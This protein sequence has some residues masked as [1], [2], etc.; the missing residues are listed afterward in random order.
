MKGR[1]K[2]AAAI[3]T[4]LLLAML[5]CTPAFA[6][7]NTSDQD[8][9]TSVSSDAREKYTQKKGGGRDKVTIMIYMIGSDLESQNGMATAD[10]NEML[11]AAP[12]NGNINMFIQTG[13]CKRWRNSIMTA[14][15]LERWKLDSSLTLLERMK[16]QSMTDPNTLASF[17][18]F[19]AKEAPADRYI[20]IFWD[21]GGGSVTGYGYDERYPNDTMDIGEIG[22]ALKT[23]A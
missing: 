14:G 9:D 10:L 7:G 23:V 21:H 6:A 11:Y 16:G 4:A 19:C 17:I 22:K 20:L 18:Q 13:G 3:L 8:V 15:K 1:A 12:D 2:R 5:L